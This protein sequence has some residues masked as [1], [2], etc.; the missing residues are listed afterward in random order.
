[1]SPPKDNCG[2]FDCMEN[3]GSGFVWQRSGVTRK[4]SSICKEE[5]LS[6]WGRFYLYFDLYEFHAL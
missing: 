1:M 5:T 3:S 6:S 2:A 4:R